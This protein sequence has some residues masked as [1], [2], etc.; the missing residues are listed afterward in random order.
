LRYEIVR[1]WHFGTAGLRP[2]MMFLWLA[3]ILTL[4]ACAGKQMEVALEGQPYP[5]RD[6]VP[7]EFSFKIKA[8]E[9]I[10]YLSTVDE[11]LLT[12]DRRLEV[13]ILRGLSEISAKDQ[14]QQV[15]DGLWES[16]PLVRKL[17]QKPGPEA[18][19]YLYPLAELYYMLNTGASDE[20]KREASERL[21]RKVFRNMHPNQLSGYALHFYTMALLKR[22]MFRE[23][24]PFFKRLRTFT[25]A[26]VYMKDMVMVIDMACRHGD[27]AYAASMMAKACGFAQANG[28]ELPE[29]EL[30][31]CLSCLV[32]A[33]KAG[34]AAK[35]ME[36]LAKASPELA[37]HPF[38]QAVMVHR[39][40]VKPTRHTVRRKSRPAIFDSRP[41]P[42]PVQAGGRE[43]EN[44]RDITVVRVQ[45]IKASRDRYYLDPALEG[46]G[47]ETLSALEFTSFSLVKENE[48]RLARG[49]SGTVSLARGQVLRINSRGR[50]Q[51]KCRLRVTIEQGHKEVFHTEL[52]SVDQGAAVIGREET[53]EDGTVLL[54]L[55]TLLP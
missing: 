35:E 20:W 54:R 49:E 15:L 38:C 30:R 40:S 50:E 17:L 34:L 48:L 43:K 3:A 45:T 26:D 23:A 13:H 12:P 29:V 55:I 25:P 22:R 41:A 18:R 8:P 2:V 1:S 47:E 36:P 16:E 9:T 53:G 11:A 51:G 7:E 6:R 10:T 19:D 37:S 39:S 21:Y 28:I 4:S 33:G 14:V 52:E 46:I 42:E 5:L 24:D 27:H 44:T 31:H 32:A